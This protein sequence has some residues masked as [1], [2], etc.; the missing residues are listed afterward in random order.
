MLK[1]FF[2][3][4]TRCVPH[5]G[6]NQ[7][8]KSILVASAICLAFAQTASAQT[9]AFTYQGKLTDAGAA[10]NGPYDFTFRLFTAVA[11]G[12]QVG[13]DVTVPVVQVTAGIFY[14]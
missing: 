10:A 5:G 4:R 11:G 9:T 13:S 8:L 14:R 2:S 1:E 12:S 3:F 6:R 7:T